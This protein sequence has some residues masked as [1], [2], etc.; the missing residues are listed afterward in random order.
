MQSS[1]FLVIV[2]FGITYI[3]ISIN[4]SLAIP[5][6]TL[7]NLRIDLF[8]NSTC[9]VFQNNTCKI[10]EDSCLIGQEC[11]RE[12]ETHSNESSSCL[13][14]L[15]KLSQTEW[16]FNPTCSAGDSCLDLSYTQS[17][18]CGLNLIIPFYINYDDAVIQYYNFRE[19]GSNER[20]CQAGF[21]F[22]KIKNKT[23]ACCPGHFCPKGQVCMIPCRTGAYCPS[24][25]PGRNGTCQTTVKCPYHQATNYDQYGCGGSIIEGFC[26]AESYCPNSSISLPCPNN[27]NYCPTGTQN[28]LPC[29]SGFVCIAGRARRTRLITLVLILVISTLIIFAVGAEISQWLSL[30]KK[31]FGQHELIDPPGVSDYFRERDPS[32]S[33]EQHIQLHIHMNRA[34]LRN[35]TRFD[36]NLNEGFTGRITAGK[37]TALMGGSGCGKSSLLETIHGRRRL[38][39]DG[40]ITF[41]KHEP[42]SNKLTDYVGYVPQA[43]IMHN[44]LTVFET[45]YYS[46]RTR[47]LNDSK[48]VIINDVCFVLEKLGL[49]TMH[50]NMTK[51]LSGGQRKRVNVAMEVAACPKVLL[52]DEPTSGLDTVSC[53][54]LFELLQLIKF[55]A[56]GPVT[57]IMVIHQPSQELFLKIDD[58]FFLTPLCCLAYQ[59]P[60]DR[61]KEYLKSKIFA[62]PR[63]CPEPRHN[64]CDTCFI[65]LTNAK[66]H[67][68]NHKVEDDRIDQPLVITSFKRRVLLPFIYCMTRSIRQT[69]IRGAVAETTYLF[70]YFLLGTCVGYLFENKQQGTCDINALPTIYFL[71]SLAYGI[72]TCISSQRLFGVEIID[73]T[74]ERESRNYFHPF[75]YWLAKS[76]IDLVRLFFYPLLFL[77][78]LF[79]EVVPRGEFSYYYGVMIL[80]TFV[81]SGIGQLV[82]VIFNKTEYAYLA[83]TIVALLS[84]LLSGFNPTKSDLG[85][86][87]FIVA[88]SFSRHIQH[89]LFRYE[90]ELYVKEQSLTNPHIWSGQV[91][92][93]QN[94]YSYTD[95]ENPYFWLIFIGLFLRA[96]TFV[97]LYAKSEYRSPIRFHVTHIIPTLKSLFKCKPCRKR[98]S[99]DDTASFRYSQHIDDSIPF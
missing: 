74:Y 52:L 18:Q 40:Y 9:A 51:N 90:T 44:D 49:K 8:C 13:Q 98:S 82:S 78:M 60:R 62:H 95:N 85:G 94:Y 45:V 79:I 19:C 65:M 89:L 81:C 80:L 67:I 15:P 14:C 24:P 84:C 28:A 36:T 99:V 55:S 75:Q 72:L 97:F 4:S 20:Q 17:E 87:Q 11:Y 3:P 64:D 50:N 57:I 53:D 70:A 5:N 73:Q 37:L 16:S 43:D 23:L 58:I 59:G 46:A 91:F 26:P 63:D 34:K 39:K 10:N 29:P 1:F 54:D 71:I 61:A 2:L 47:R 12:N 93:L 27:T 31:S 7:N 69:Y 41:A 30:T 35:V 68:D 38:Q 96:L 48:K 25:L 88:I 92:R 86:G 83:G 21:F 42:L 76:I 32:T 77:S 33:P 66:K 22:S 56:A 6:D